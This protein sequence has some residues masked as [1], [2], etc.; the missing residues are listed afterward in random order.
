M[1]VSTGRPDAATIQEL[2]IRAVSDETE[3]SAAAPPIDP[4][5]DSFQD[6]GLDSLG[7]VNVA[8][9]MEADLGVPVP[10]VLFFDHP[11]IDALSRH[12]ADEG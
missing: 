10:P 6:L 2:L 8:K 1:T 7:A 9:R 5:E 3:R 12:L 4:E 11:T